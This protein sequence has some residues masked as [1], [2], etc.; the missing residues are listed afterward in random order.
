MYKVIAIFKLTLSDF[1]SFFKESKGDE[2]SNKKR[3]EDIEKSYR[4]EIN[5]NTKTIE[6]KK[7]YT[8][9]EKHKG[10]TNGHR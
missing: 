9:K 2:M 3:N 8:R 1:F 4:R 6:S 7:K 5:L 10:A